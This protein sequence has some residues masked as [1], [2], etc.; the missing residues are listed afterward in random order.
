MENQAIR[1]S[2]LVQRCQ[3]ALNDSSTLHAVGL[4][5]VPGHAGV[6]GNEIANGLAKGGSASRFVGY[7]PAL[8]VSR[9]VIRRISHW[10]VNQHWG[11][12]WSLGNTQRQ[13][14][15][16]ISG[17]CLGTKARFFIFVL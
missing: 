11:W 6:R 10:L 17:P 16:L 13:A 15:E 2:L 7:E 3:K 5:C 4:Y 14:S 8:G 12:C 9:L 1:T